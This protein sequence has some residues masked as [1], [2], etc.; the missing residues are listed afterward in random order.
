LE[1]YLRGED[2]WTAHDHDVA[3]QA[4]NEYVSDRGLGHPVRYSEEF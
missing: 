4:I 2:E 1:R 3:A